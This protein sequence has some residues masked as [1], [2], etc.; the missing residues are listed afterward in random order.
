MNAEKSEC[1]KLVCPPSQ[2]PSLKTNKCISLICPPKYVF[3]D[4]KTECIKLVCPSGQRPS[5]K[6]NKCVTLV[7]PLGY[8]MNAEKTECFKLECKDP[9]MILEKNQCVCKSE[10]EMK[11]LSGSKKCA[12][13]T[14][15]LGFELRGDKCI[16]VSCPPGYKIN[17]GAKK[18]EKLD[19][20]H[21][22]METDKENN[23]CKCKKK[24][25][26]K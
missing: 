18:C 6:N 14:C 24:Y 19:C 10:F 21:D 9:N 12:K 22:H 5:L 4:K 25:E 2:R 11:E 3:N 20:D 16:L 13:K 8:V 17:K 15:P 23:I 26:M 1:V 7:C